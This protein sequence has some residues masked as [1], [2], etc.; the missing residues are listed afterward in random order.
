MGVRTISQTIDLKNQ[1]GAAATSKYITDISSTGIT[2]HPSTVGQNIY[3]TQ[4]SD[5]F[6]IKQMAGS[7]ID[8]T[9]DTTLTSIK[10]NDII[11][12]NSTSYNTHITNQGL[13]LRNANTDYLSLTTNGINL[14]V[15][16]QAHTV[17]DADSMTIYNNTNKLVD[18]K[19]T[20]NTKGMLI[21]D[22]QGNNSQNILATFLDNQFSYQTQGIPI[23]EV[24]NATQSP[25]VK[26]TKFQNWEIDYQTEV[27][28]FVP[29]YRMTDFVELLI[30]VTH[31]QTGTQSQ[32]TETFTTITL[33][34]SSPTATIYD[35][36]NIISCECIPSTNVSEMGMMKIT[37]T[38]SSRYLRI[39]HLTLT[40]LSEAIG[41]SKI[42]CGAYPNKTDVNLFT[43]GN[44]KNA[45]NPTNALVVDWEGNV[46]ITG[47]YYAP[48]I[49]NANTEIIN[50]VTLTTADTVANIYVDSATCF[51]RVVHG[52]F[53]LEID[54]SWAAGKN[55]NG[56]VTYVDGFAPQNQADGIGYFGSGI[57]SCRLWNNGDI[58]FRNTTAINGS[59]DTQTVYCS[60]TWIR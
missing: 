50:D 46:N 4:I 43:I 33:T 41:V 19:G 59:T 24:S 51:G 48:L 8:T 49:T 34:P 53:K 29:N 10:A 22:G 37:I 36:S 1:L 13:F 27:I 25:Y 55:V 35:S 9:N 21:Y 14:G 3:Y 54:D 16:N 45:L 23:F 52:V 39:G 12:G 11:V 26:E 60:V 5:G 6:Y 30:E 18:I 57:V 32:R 2:I 56:K 31:G 40:Y 17:I 47:N 42:F 7:N 28:T 44:G 38:S 58:R 20:S 15:S